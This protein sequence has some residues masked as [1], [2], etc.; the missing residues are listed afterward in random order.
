METKLNFP[1]TDFADFYGPGYTNV[2][3]YTD[4]KYTVGIAPT[5][6]NV[7]VHD[8]LFQSCSSSSSGGAISCSSS[9]YKL[10]VYQASFISCTTSNNRGGGVYLESTTYGECI[11]SRICGFNCSSTYSSGSSH[12]QF[13]YIS[14]KN[15]ATYKSHVNDSSITHSLGVSTNS[16]DT[17]SIRSGNILFPSVNITNNVCDLYTAFRV[18]PTMGTGSPISETFCISYSSVVNNTNIRYYGCL[19]FDRPDSSARV[20]T[21]NILDNKQTS[22][23]YGTIYVYANLLIENSCI[24]GNN[25]NNKVFYEGTS[26]N[27]IT[28]S[29]CT[30]DDDIFT[31]GRYYG[32]VTVIKTIDRTFIHALSHISTRNCDSFFDSYGTLS[33]KPNLPSKVSHCLISCNCKYQTNELYMHMQ[34]IFLLTFLP[35]DP[36]ND[37]SLGLNCLF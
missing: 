26:S 21:C 7:Y 23:N 14:I 28:I 18:F 35:A 6:Q 19:V 24:L 12:G 36:A 29:N 34:F 10:L 5:D 25:E 32:S 33:V 4:P 20:N 17:L 11:F 31:N 30:L 27:K 15:D 13:A 2:K 1:K 3:Q 16:W 9:V 22:S 8:C 37:Y